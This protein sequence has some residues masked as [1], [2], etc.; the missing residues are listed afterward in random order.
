MDYLLRI[1][2]A[3]GFFFDV[4]VCLFYLTSENVAN[5]LHTYFSWE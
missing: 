5:S 2:L 4:C 3:L 1:N